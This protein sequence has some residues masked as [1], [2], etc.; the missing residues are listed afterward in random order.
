MITNSIDSVVGFD[1]NDGLS[2]VI[3]T[4]NQTRGN[5]N[6]GKILNSIAVFYGS[7]YQASLEQKPSQGIEGKYWIRDKEGLYVGTLII[8]PKDPFSRTPSRKT[9]RMENHDYPMAYGA[10]NRTRFFEK[11]WIKFPRYTDDVLKA[12]QVGSLIFALGQNAKNFQR[13][14]DGRRV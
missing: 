8:E 6:M 9:R 3:E 1:R 5:S 12:Q 11:Y 4:S 2:L 10:H 13:R 14:Y 7:S